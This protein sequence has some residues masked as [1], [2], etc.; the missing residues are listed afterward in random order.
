MQTAPMNQRRSITSEAETS[1]KRKRRKNTKTQEKS[2][3]WEHV[4]DPVFEFRLCLIVL[5]AFLLFWLLVYATGFGKGFQ[6]IVFGMPHHELDHALAGWFCGYTS[7]P[8]V[9]KTLTPESRGF[10]APL[11]VF[12]GLVYGGYL[13]FTKKQP[14]LV[15]LCV[16]LFILQL[17]GTLGL[18]KKY[19]GWSSCLAVKDW[20]W[21]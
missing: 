18:E 2:A 9:W 20:A 16:L 4:K 14:G 21:L 17:T 15:V 13:S 3:D 7:I 12:G 5:P 10:I 1:A 11:V 8:K 19:P 6:A